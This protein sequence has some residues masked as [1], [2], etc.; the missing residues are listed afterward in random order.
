MQVPEASVSTH[1]AFLIAFFGCA[2]KG[3][4]EAIRQGRRYYLLRHCCQCLDQLVSANTAKHVKDGFIRVLAT[5]PRREDA[6]PFWMFYPRGG[7]A[8]NRRGKQ[9]WPLGW[10]SHVS[11]IG[12]SAA[13]K[14]MSSN[15]RTLAG[16]TRLSTS[17]D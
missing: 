16:R 14:L 8:R 15:S 10:V 7:A 3:H 12:E 6:D 4:I 17:H 11:W 5:P 2:P 9:A 13:E 1:L